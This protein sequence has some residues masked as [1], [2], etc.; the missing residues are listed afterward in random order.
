MK[1]FRIALLLIFSFCLV[2]SNVVSAS[3]H[4]VNIFAYVEGNTVYSE[5]YFSKKNRV[6]QGK[7]T[8]FE[9]ESGN[10]LLSG[11]TDDDGNFNFPIPK[12]VI[13]NKTGLKIVLNASQGHR[14]E[15]DLQ[16]SEIKPDLD[17]KIEKT[18]SPV[19]TILNQD[20]K[21]TT[22]TIINSELNNRL[23]KMES[24]LTAIKSILISQQETGPSM[25]DI[26]SGIGYIFGLFGVAAFIASKNKTV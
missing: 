9:L 3:A 14:N 15:W 2:C 26:I 16:A 6:H 8:V 22:P 5:S 17:T 12:E 1:Y 18:P 4:R 23:K 7:I 25:Q 11:R 19:N 24:E 13:K 20:K 21:E 10:Q